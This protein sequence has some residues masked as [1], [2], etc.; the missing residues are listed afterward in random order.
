[1]GKSRFSL[2]N[3][4]HRSKCNAKFQK[5]DLKHLRIDDNFKS[6]STHK[7]RKRPGVATIISG[8]E[9]IAWNWA[10]IGSPPNTNMVFKS[11]YLPIS[12]MNLNVCT[13]NSRVGDR[14]RARAFAVGFLVCNFSNIGIRK[15]AV[16][17]EPLIRNTMKQTFRLTR[18]PQYE[19][20]ALSKI[21]IAQ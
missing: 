7:C 6:I 15:H 5:E 2:L 16:L 13:A 17:P 9:C 20:Q 11:I 10:L 18:I 1:M 19:S 12:L 8:H 14:I 21:T 4:V 3:G